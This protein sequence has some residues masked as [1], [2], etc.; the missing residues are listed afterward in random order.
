MHYIHPGL[1][2]WKSM[3]CGEHSLALVLLVEITMRPAIQSEW[4]T[5]QECPKVVVF[6]KVGDAV[7]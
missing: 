2:V 4:S 6:I 7:L 1:D 3:R 5:E